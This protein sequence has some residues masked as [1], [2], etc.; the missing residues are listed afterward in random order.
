MPDEFDSETGMTV[1][2]VYKREYPKKSAVIVS[3]A[4]TRQSDGFSALLTKA[5]FARMVLRREPPFDN[6]DFTGF[7]GTFR[8]MQSIVDDYHY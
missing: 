2:G 5:D 7:R 6:M 4:V 1:D 3:D 8:V